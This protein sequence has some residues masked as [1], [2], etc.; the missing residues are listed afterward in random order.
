LG[1]TGAQTVEVADPQ[2]CELTI[3]EGLD[4]ETCPAGSNLGGGALV[5]DLGLC[6]A[7]T[8][9]E[10]CEAGT[11]LEGVWV[12]PDELAT[13]NIAIPP[14]ITTF[15]CAPDDP[16][17]NA[18]VTDPRL[19]QFEDIELFECPEEGS[20]PALVGLNVTA[21]P[22]CQA[23]NNA[24]ICG[25]DTGL[26][27]VFV[28]NTATDCVTG[29]SPTTNPEAQCIKC[30]DLAV[31]QALNVVG[32]GANQNFPQR[33]ASSDLFATP[34]NVFTLCQAENPIPGFNA[35]VNITNAAQEALIEAGFAT[36]INNAPDPAP[37]LSVSQAPTLSLQENS[38]TTNVI[39]EAGIPLF[40]S[41]SARETEDLSALEKIEKLKQQWMELTP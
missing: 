39:P 24:N 13:C 28:N 12:H 29:G 7:A 21:L 20:N 10:Q 8:P 34:D 27:G 11:T 3:P 14:P 37:T 41:P 33:E 17:S 22:L 16:L 4:L 9:A 30:A 6:D 2:L 1:L 35:R 23:P 18:V 5:T 38:F 32:A 25:P 19:C 36:C 40:S 26:P 31:F 15:Q